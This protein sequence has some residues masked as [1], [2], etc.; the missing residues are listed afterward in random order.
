VTSSAA[1]GAGKR[2]DMT[3]RKES[4]GRLAELARFPEENPDPVLRIAPDLTVRYANQAARSQLRGLQ[5]ETGQAA[6]AALAEAARFASAEGHAVRSEI[7]CGDRVLALNFVPADGNVN[8]YGHDVTERKRAEEALR[9]SESRYRTLFDSIDEGFCVIEVLFDDARNPIDYRFLEVNRA[10]ERQTGLANATGRRMRELA[11]SHEEHWFRI[12]GEIALTG[13]PNRFENRAEALGRWYDVYAFRV[14][15][16]DQRRVAILFSDIT[17]RKRDEE[18]LRNANK[19]LQEADRHKDEF[20]AMLSHELRNPL[21]PIR[22]SIYV[23]SR[24]SPGGEQARRAHAVID[25]Q[26]HHMTRLVDDLL[27][28]TRISRGKIR[29]Q[30]ERLELNGLI[31][32]TA[33]DHREDFANGGIGLDVAVAEGPV[34][35][36]GDATRLAQVIGNLLQNSA[37]FTPRGGRAT[38]SVETDRRTATITVRDS[39]VGIAPD[40]LPQLFQPFVQG[41][42]TL[43]RTRGGLGLGLALV[44]GLVKLHGGTVSAH[45]AGAGKG[46]AFVVRLPLAPA[47]EPRVPVAPPRG[48]EAPRRVLVIEDNHDAAESMREALQMNAHEVEVALTG[49]EGLAKARASRPDVILCDIGLPEMSGYE[50]ARAMRADPELRS[51]PLVALSGYA[52]PEDLEKSRDAGFDRHL[53][54]PMEFELL[55]KVLTEVQ[56]ASS[57]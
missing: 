4:E 27:D 34:H 30:R 45:S 18:A 52:L 24:A 3:N 10:F 2:R 25:R 49:S 26:V 15:Y 40:V 48:R 47:D 38:L 42:R 57:G 9:E 1:R 12:Y 13:E 5:L 36:S 20:L 23:L 6:P 33:E 41:D 35:V 16:P 50:V 53:A 31:L 39:G 17:E 32:R 54:K 11:P 43:D 55:E 28:V 56:A 29:L 21:A 22:N 46:A 14:G 8:V 37:K 44:N 51:I 19:L 7:T